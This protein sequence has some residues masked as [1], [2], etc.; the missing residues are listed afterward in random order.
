MCNV[1]SVTSSTWGG[2]CVETVKPWELRVGSSGILTVT[3]IGQLLCSWEPLSATCPSSSTRSLCT[4]RERVMLFKH[5]SK[6]KK[7]KKQRYMF[8]QSFS[9]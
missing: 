9:D 5:K 3:L 7:R 6:K 8:T 1:P 2:V 4:D